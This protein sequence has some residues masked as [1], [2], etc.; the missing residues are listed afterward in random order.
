MGPE[1]KLCERSRMS[2]LFN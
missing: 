2:S 1:N